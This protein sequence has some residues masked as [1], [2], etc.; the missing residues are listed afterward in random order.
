LFIGIELVRNRTA[1]EPA[2]EEAIYI[3][4]RMKD[5]GILITT[6]GKDD[7][8]LTIKPPLVFTKENADFLANTLDAILREDQVRLSNLDK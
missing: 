7:N 8:V 2:I 6:D 1:R 5:Y 3:Y 4:E